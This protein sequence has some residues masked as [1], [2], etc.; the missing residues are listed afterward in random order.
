MER[1]RLELK[2]AAGPLAW[3]FVT[4]LFGLLT[5]G[6][7]LSK[8]N[9][10]YPWESPY[11]VKL[12]VSD[13]KGITPPTQLVRMAGVE[14]GTVDA[15][16]L[17]GNKPVLTLN[18]DPEHAPIYRDATFRV[19]PLTPLEDLYVAVDDRGT[20]E[21]GRLDGSTTALA[22]QVTTPVHISK[23]LNIFQP[24]TRESMGVTFNELA[25]GAPDNGA[26]LR[27][28]LR[29]LAPFLEVADEVTEVVNER[30]V[31]ARRGMHNFSEL[32]EAIG[33]RDRQLA[34]LIRNGDIALGELD[35]SSRPFDRTLRELPPTMIALQDSLSTVRLAADDIDPG[36]RALQPVARDLP[37]GMQALERF[38]N[39]A[40]PALDRLQPALVEARPLANEL[41]PTAEELNELVQRLQPQAQRF[42][43]I[44]ALVPP[45][46]STVQDFFNNTISVFKFY[47]SFGS[48][49]RGN[50][51][52]DASSFGGTGAETLDQQTTCT[53]ESSPG[54][55]GRRR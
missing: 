42:D 1:L 32:V 39:A 9:I 2:R 4:A 27:M 53:G 31:L 43:Q 35:R 5:A 28:A 51:T 37:A 3:V 12:A 6:T 30:R 20:P 46:F 41:R 23:V 11:Y 52:T 24:D 21:A 45:C 36:L 50:N 47:D 34:S 26:N 48:F 17:Q 22:Q 10:T 14:I 29:Q 19:R 33:E 8:I 25:K 13:A 40:N 49:P 18:I 38:A 15:V 16:E 55:G 54:P 7:I 44:T